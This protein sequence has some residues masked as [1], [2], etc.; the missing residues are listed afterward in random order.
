MKTLFKY[1]G[2][3]A[4]PPHRGRS[5]SLHLSLSLSHSL[6]F[7]TRPLL[8]CDKDLSFL[9]GIK[10]SWMW[11]SNRADAADYK[12]PISF[13]AIFSLHWKKTSS[14][15]FKG[16]ELGFVIDVVVV[17][18]IVV[19]I[20]VVVDVV[21]VV[22][23]VVVVVGLSQGLSSL[24][25][26][27]FRQ[28]SFFFFLSNT[29]T[30]SLIHTHT[31][32]QTLTLTDR[33]LTWNDSKGTNS[34]FVLKC[35]WSPLAGTRESSKNQPRRWY[36]MWDGTSFSVKLLLIGSSL[37]KELRQNNLGLLYLRKEN[38]RSSSHSYSRG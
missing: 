21:E 2:V 9:S 27:I 3:D 30:L 8:K 23:V 10:R 19:V 34:R 32:T 16:S 12:V 5:L 17:V 37:I 35:F 22:N 4:S 33:V 20:V 28:Q 11:P 14:Y 31:H 29:L 13:S 7:L 36:F 25:K 26:L 38:L 1:S 24:S 18:D 15:F 6:I